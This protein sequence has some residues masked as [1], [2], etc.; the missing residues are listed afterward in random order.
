MGNKIPHL[1]MS[2]IFQSLVR[3]AT[4]GMLC[5]YGAAACLHGLFLIGLLVP[6]DPYTCDRVL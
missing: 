4:A 6:G 1:M 5:A 2:L 3:N